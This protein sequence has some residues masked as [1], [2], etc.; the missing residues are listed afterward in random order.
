[1]F[2]PGLTG[3]NNKEGIANGL[4]TRL[5]I[6]YAVEGDLRYISHHDSLRL[7]ERAM[8]RARIPVRYSEGFN[9]KPRMRIALP[10]SVGVASKDE[11]LLVELTSD[12]PT[13]DVLQSLKIEMPPGLELLTVELLEQD[14]RRLPREAWYTASVDGSAREALTLAANRLLSQEHVPVQRSA[15]GEPEKSIDIR[16]YISTFEVGPDSVTWSQKITPEGT[17]RPG[18]VLEQ[19]GLPSRDHLHHLCRTRV[20]YDR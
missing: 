15:P 6:Q 3:K 19:L 14:D 8:A 18:E 1:M 9:P 17:A 11:L 10:R 20:L 7:F 4:R 5:A 13:S 16:P 12:A 2:A